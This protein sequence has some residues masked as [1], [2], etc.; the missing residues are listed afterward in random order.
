MNRRIVAVVFLL[1]LALS[2]MMSYSLWESYFPEYV[3]GPLPWMA[4]GLRLSYRVDTAVMKRGGGLSD[5]GGSGTG[6][7]QMDFVAVEQDS[8]AILSTY[9]MTMNGG[10]YPGA[11]YGAL[12]KPGISDF[13]LNP[14]VFKDLSR[15]N[16]DNTTAMAMPLQFGGQTLQVV[17]VETTGVDTKHVYTY[18]A[19]S[20]LLIYLLMQIPS[21]ENIQQS[22]ME[23][24][25]ARYIDL[26]WA[27]SPRPS[28]SMTDTLY[29]GTY[30]INIPGSYTTPLQMQ[31]NVTPLKSSQ[32]WDLIKMTI[33]QYGILPSEVTTVTGI[34]QI[35]GAFW[36]CPQALKS[37]NRV[38][39][40][41]RDPVTGVVTEVVFAG[42]LQDGTNAIMLQQSNGTYMNQYLYD[43]NTGRLIY[44]KLQ[45]P[46]SLSYNVT[47]LSL[48]R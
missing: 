34:A 15:F 40:I 5:T 45:S 10:Y 41:D 4:P 25:S 44:I 6:I 21:G 11:S 24:I 3:N 48:I 43:Q 23:F 16:S 12:E 27:N 33:S 29:G 39:T 36:L 9:F 14:E 31:V 2:S 46:N 42:K 35:S 38:Q 7:Q 20:G 26:P 17:R 8:T 30:T 37:L 1:F 32:S 28:W 18:D 47:E 13:W 19:A 22:Y